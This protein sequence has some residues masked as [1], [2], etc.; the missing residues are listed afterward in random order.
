M[1]APPPYVLLVEDEAPLRKFL[2]ASLASAGYRLDEACSGQDALAKAAQRPPDLVILDLGLPDMDGQQVLQQ[3]RE[4]LQA[5]IIILS[6]RD[7][8]QQKVAALD[9]GADDYLTKPFSTVELLARIRV[10]LR[11]AARRVGDAD[12]TSV[13]CGEM[14][15]DLS[16]RKVTV[17]GMKRITSASSWPT[18]AASSSSIPHDRATCSRNKESAI[19]WPVSR[20]R[21]RI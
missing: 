16:G 21:I 4:W 11:H 8:E 7:Q 19:D 12:V 1:P 14:R 2:A 10:A 3:L 9:H 20:R 6:A 15:I 13:E 18:Y 5:P 17:R